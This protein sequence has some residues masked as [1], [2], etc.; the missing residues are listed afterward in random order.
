M[1]C[2]ISL[3][4]A[5]ILCLN[6][7]IPV[8]L[9]EENGYIYISTS[10]D[11]VDLSNNCMIDS[12]SV[13][14]TILLK[15]DI[16]MKG[17]DFNPIGFM[18][19]VFDGCG[20]KISG[21]RFEFSD[22]ERGFITTVGEQGVVKN[23]K[24][25]AQIKESS[26]K[27]EDTK[28]NIIDTITD[29]IKDG[30]PSELDRYTDSD[31]VYIIGGI[32]GI[33]KGLIE[34]CEFEGNI[35]AS[36]AVGGIAGLNDK[37]GIINTSKNRGT[38]I[39]KEYSGGIAGKNNGV[40]H[41]CENF[42][43]INNEPQ[44]SA[45]NIGG[46][47]GFSD[48]AVM[49]S[50]N[51]S[52]IGY[53]NTGT[54][55]GGIMGS[56]SGYAAECI[57]YG[58]VYGKHEVGGIVGHF[59]PYINI[60]FTADD[61]QKRINETSDKIKDNINEIQDGVDKNVDNVHDSLK[62]LREN[63]FP[64]L[65]NGSTSASILPALAALAGGTEGG[66]TSG[67]LDSMKNVADSLTEMNNTING[68]VGD[69]STSES[70]N[71][72]INSLGELT[73][74]LRDSTN[75]LTDSLKSNTDQLNSMVS[76]ADNA[77]GRIANN[78]DTLS[79]D[80]TQSSQKLT[81]VLDTL[82]K[83]L[84][85]SNADRDDLIDAL[86]TALDELDFNVNVNMDGLSLTATDRQLA[87]SISNSFSQLNSNI[88]AILRPYVKISNAI[89]EILDS[90]SEGSSNIKKL[91][92]QLKKLLEDLLDQLR[93]MPE[94]TTLPLVT[95]KPDRG[96]VSELLFTTAYAE[97]DNE[98]TTL[99]KLAD[100]DIKDL[101]IEIDR[102]LGNTRYDAALIKYCINNGEVYGFSDVGGIAGSVGLESKIVSAKDNVKKEGTISLNPSTAIKAVISTS[103]NSGEISARN[104]SAGGITGFSDLGSIKESINTGAI[105]VTDGA[106]AGGISGYNMH[107]ITRCINTGDTDAQ[108]D[109]GGI[110]GIGTNIEGCYALAR[111]SSTGARQGAIAGS[112]SGDIK[113]NYFLKEDLGGINGVDYSAKAQSV[114]KE[115]LARDGSIAPELA[116]FNDGNWFAQGGGLYMPQLTAFTNN[117]ASGLSDMLKAI[118][119][120]CAEFKFD[121]IFIKDGQQ[122][123][124]LKLNYGDTLKD[125]DIPVLE[126]R[127]GEY[128]VWD[129]DT[130]QKIIRDTKF[131][132][133]YNRSKSTLSYGG[134]PPI[135]LAEGNF[136]PE[137][138]L[139]VEEFDASNIVNS[140]KYK[141]AGGYR[142]KVT[143][144]GREYEDELT[145]RIRDDKKNNTAIGIIESG[146]VVITECERDG[147]YV[148][149][150][151]NAPVQFVLLH[152]KSMVPLIVGMIILLLLIIGTLLFIFRRKIIA[153]LAMR[154]AAIKE[155]ITLRLGTGTEEQNNNTDSAPEQENSVELNDDEAPKNSNKDT[156]KEQEVGNEA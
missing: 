144:D 88:N 152:K 95:P 135:L 125:S 67:L 150:K 92:E 39:A 46:I 50:Y 101:D 7:F 122:V 113:N 74:S 62:D 14:K 94:P 124:S 4:L 75:E 37:T 30:L 83:T 28:L 85:D 57:N 65:Q 137:A 84:N 19:G 121:V 25:E 11:L 45:K 102:K 117:T 17:V 87:Q 127:N 149:F 10:A 142:V 32:C 119:A 123:G 93:S 107:N 12:Y 78:A 126:K 148:K 103:V 109:L 143:E 54:N 81:Q 41:W 129:K 112:T 49:E 153:R 51:H 23:L 118:S 120:D 98:K 133:L 2:K 1:K 66:G 86:T 13:G 36:K 63:L 140:E 6:I 136:R 3:L 116:G 151:A 132:A 106:Y 104:T 42:G 21:L 29:S 16:D 68:R 55:V 115:V 35:K 91:V 79:A 70:L 34:N 48:G 145:V 5:F 146:A 8:T 26:S 22:P 77:I 96:A 71:S 18:G 72:S 33:N 141:T 147:S 130:S 73:E 15:N 61:I 69:T 38:V 111:T 139:T 90:I 40:I 27:K 155:K 97:E 56:Q 9:A 52:T 105:K 59:E 47:C 58:T 20:Y 156:E 43:I 108:S 89:M 76:S 110:A 114:T 128:G 100:L 82:D 99:Q 31:G 80:F 53:K 24:I 138:E 154:R 60:N 44:E 64:S 134:E 131:T